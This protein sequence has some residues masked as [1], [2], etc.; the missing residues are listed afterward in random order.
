VPVSVVA[1]NKD[2]EFEFSQFRHFLD[3]HAQP[4]ASGMVNDSDM[5]ILCFELIHDQ[6]GSVGASIVD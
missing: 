6:P 4:A 2:E 3:G 5:R 1:R